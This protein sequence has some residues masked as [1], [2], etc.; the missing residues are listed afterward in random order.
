MRRR[1]TSTLT[2]ALFAVLSVY[3][4]AS[5]EEQVVLTLK[6]GT[7]LAGRIEKEQDGRLTFR[8]SGG[9]SIELLASDV[10]KI[11]RAS[12][13]T[14]GPQ[15]Q[16]GDPNY[17]RLFFAPTARTLKRGTGY[18]ADYYIFFP[19]LA[20][21]ATDRLT[22]YGAMSIIPGLS[23]SEQLFFFAPKL[24]V[25]QEE[26]FALAAGFMAIDIPESDIIPGIVYGVSTWGTKDRSLTAGAGWGWVRDEGDWEYMDRPMIMIGGEHRVSSS[27]KLLTENWWVP[28][29][30]AKEHP[31]LS[32][33]VRFFGEHLAAD[34][35]LFHVAGSGME[36]FPFIPWVDFAYNF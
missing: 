2:L 29:D 33:G 10:G 7:T 12:E 34:I 19:S 14:D 31:V 9:V 8:T 11:E 15:Y 17:T 21:G 26:S 22:L 6:D 35:G 16:Y 36:G 25:V 13:E 30:E 3:P 27:M 1:I 18:F 4:A 24:G 32:F 23:L 5:A 20:Y 28:I